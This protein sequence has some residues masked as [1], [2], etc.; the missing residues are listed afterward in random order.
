MIINIL[1]VTMAREVYKEFAGLT[2]SGCLVIDR[3]DE[4][5][6]LTPCCAAFV[7]YCDTSLC[8][9]SCYGEADNEHLLPA[10]VAVP[11]PLINTVIP[12]RPRR[13]KKNK[14]KGS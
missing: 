11:A 8:C 6:A 5:T 3:D 2:A 7:T 9:K 14:K 12:G 4:L 1:A 10:Q 13:R